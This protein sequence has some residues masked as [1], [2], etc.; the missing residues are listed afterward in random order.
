MTTAGDFS[1]RMRELASRAERA[2]GDLPTALWVGTIIIVGVLVAV[3]AVGG[4]NPAQSSPTVLDRGEE[5]RTSV[6]SVA[7]LDGEFTDTVESEFLEAE[8]GETLL[9]LTLR[10][11]NL[12]DQAIGVG[13]S[14]DRITSNLIGTARPLLA[15]S[16]TEA[17]GSAR[18]WRA[19]GSSGGVVLQ[20]GVPSEVTI[21]WPVPDD[22]FADGIITLDVHEATVRGGAVILSSNVV[23]WRPAEIAAQIRTTVKQTS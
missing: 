3:I 6:Y 23:S 7:V 20:P 4:L 21:A 2:L 11:E 19:D 13:T 10:M 1:G 22:A 5:A 17:T 12:S 18:A 15:L 9:V 8:P 16:G 14:A